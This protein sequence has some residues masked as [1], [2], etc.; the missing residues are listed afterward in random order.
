M[1]WGLISPGKEKQDK[2]QG[3][4]WVVNP[5]KTVEVDRLEQET[6]TGNI[7]YFAAL[8]RASSVASQS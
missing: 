4:R 1:V 5:E 6:W 3:V 8:S 2:N 7:N